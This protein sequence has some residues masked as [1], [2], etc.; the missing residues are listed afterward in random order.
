MGDHQRLG[1]VGEGL[2]VADQP[3]RQGDGQHDQPGPRRAAH[4]VDGGQPR[5]EPGGDDQAEEEHDDVGVQPRD[6]AGDETE[7]VGLVG[8]AGVGRSR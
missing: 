6:G 5:R 2:H 3:L 7:P 4:A 8:V 1:Q